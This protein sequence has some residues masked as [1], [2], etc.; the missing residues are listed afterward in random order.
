MKE[1]SFEIC[2]A[3][4]SMRSYIKAERFASLASVS[5]QQFW[6][7]KGIGQLNLVPKIVRQPFFLITHSSRG[8]LSN[9]QFWQQRTI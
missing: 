3:C 9:P 7:E 1:V 4:R 8:D 2:V 6:Y 5:T